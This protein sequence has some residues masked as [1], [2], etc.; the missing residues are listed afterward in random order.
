MV[1]D[2]CGFHPRGGLEGDEARG[3]R[4]SVDP[5]GAGLGWMDGRLEVK[6]K[7]MDSA[8]LGRWKGMN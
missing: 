7:W 6:G 2:P 5:G 4:P 8:M 3:P 1:N